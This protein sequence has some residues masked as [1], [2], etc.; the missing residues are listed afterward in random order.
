MDAFPRDE[1]APKVEAVPAEPSGMFCV[2]AG[3]R[4]GRAALEASRVGGE[5]ALGTVVRGVVAMEG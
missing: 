3:V 2:L 4:G 5:L 1:V